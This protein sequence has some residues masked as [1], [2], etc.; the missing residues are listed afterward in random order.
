[1]SAYSNKYRLLESCVPKLEGNTKEDLL[2]ILLS[3]QD[4]KIT[5]KLVLNVMYT[6]IMNIKRLICKTNTSYINNFDI[7]SNIETQQ[8]ILSTVKYSKNINIFETMILAMEKK[9]EDN[10]RDKQIISVS[11]CLSA[12]EAIDLQYKFGQKFIETIK[13]YAQ[14]GMN[15]E[16]MFMEYMRLLVSDSV[17]EN[18]LSSLCSA[19]TKII[20]NEKKSNKNQ[21]KKTPYK[22][23]PSNNEPTINNKFSST[24]DEDHSFNISKC[25]PSGEITNQSEVFSLLYMLINIIELSE[26]KTGI[27]TYRHFK[28]INDIGFDENENDDDVHYCIKYF[29]DSNILAMISLVKLWNGVDHE[30]IENISSLC[31]RYPEND[32]VINIAAPFLNLIISSMFTLI[33]VL[34]EVIKADNYSYFIKLDVLMNKISKSLDNNLNNQIQLYTKIYNKLNIKAN[35]IHCIKYLHSIYNKCFPDIPSE[36]DAT[37]SICHKQKIEQRPKKDKAF[38]LPLDH[39]TNSTKNNI[40]IQQIEQEQEQEQSDEEENNISIISVPKSIHYLSQLN[41][42]PLPKYHPRVS[43]WINM[44]YNQPIPFDQY[45]LKDRLYQNLM[46]MKH[47]FCFDIDRLIYNPKY[48]LTV[49]RDDVTYYYMIIYYQVKHFHFDNHNYG[50]IEYAMNNKKQI[51]HRFINQRKPSDLYRY[52]LTSQYPSNCIKE[53]KFSSNIDNKDAIIYNTDYIVGYDESSQKYI[54]YNKQRTEQ[55][56]IFPLNFYD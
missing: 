46:I 24:S 33:N 45:S 34:D 49:K 50:Y 38:P 6:S 26:H 17:P 13:L 21:S 55:F 48:C 42:I 10:D 35:S 54:F 31:E 4:E 39:E 9:I 52:M 37:I 43:R 32:R 16:L 51:F 14:I 36:H 27:S 12:L 47:G 29:V 44:D 1:M 8:R 15:R 40:V 41:N 7:C 3:S 23:P 20:D 2:K 25:I 22:N 19:A 11:D 53:Q 56:I 28:K 18:E 5:K 30:N